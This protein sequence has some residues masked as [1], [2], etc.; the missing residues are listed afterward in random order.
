MR[1][2]PLAVWGHRLTPA[3][4]AECA[5]LDASLSHPNPA[6][7]EASA[8]YVIAL[9][10]LVAQPGD[11]AGALA[12]AIAWAEEHAGQWSLSAA[13]G[14]CW[15]SPVACRSFEATL[16]QSARALVLPALPARTERSNPG[17]H[18]L[19]ADEK[20]QEWMPTARRAPSN[21]QQQHNFSS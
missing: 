21:L 5:V 17:A 18:R 13:G 1:A 4:L 2:A 7:G 20:V 3:A 9:A 16:H 6:C 14:G 19:P 8:A 10:R 15:V 12:A 11:A